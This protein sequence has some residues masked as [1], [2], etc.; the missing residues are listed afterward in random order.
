MGPKF[1][2]LTAYELE[3]EKENFQSFLPMFLPPGSCWENRWL[4]LPCNLAGGLWSLDSLNMTAV[5]SSEPPRRGGWSVSLA[6]FQSVR[7]WQAGELLVLRACHWELVTWNAP[8]CLSCMVKLH[9]YSP[10][11]TPLLV[12][13][14]HSVNK[15]FLAWKH[16]V[17]LL[18]PPWFFLALCKLTQEYF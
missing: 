6:C 12:P 18:H 10:S 17:F 11:K 13:N 2:S 8:T 9:W 14:Q 7:F 5:P 16:C 1:H 3:Y 4:E 15:I